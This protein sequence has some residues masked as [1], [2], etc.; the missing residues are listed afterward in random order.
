MPKRSDGS[1]ME[2]YDLETP[3]IASI[4]VIHPLMQWIP[5]FPQVSGIFNETVAFRQKA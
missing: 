1:T 3:G 4:P 2:P 5:G